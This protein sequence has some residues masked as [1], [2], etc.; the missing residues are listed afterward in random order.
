[1]DFICPAVCYTKGK[2]KR[3]FYEKKRK[4]ICDDQFCSGDMLV[5]HQLSHDFL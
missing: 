3:A 2:D 4:I 1:M 5:F